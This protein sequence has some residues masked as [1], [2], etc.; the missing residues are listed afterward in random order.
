MET[1]DRKRSFTAI[2][3]HL[4]KGRFSKFDADDPVVRNIVSVQGRMRAKTQKIVE[5]HELRMGNA[6]ETPLANLKASKAH[7]E[8]EL[9]ATLPMVDRQREATGAEVAKLQ[10]V[11]DD[12][13]AD[14]ALNWAYAKETRE[15]VKSLPKGVR[16]DF[17]SNALATGQTRAAA[18]VLGVPAYLSGLSEGERNLF[19]H[20]YKEESHPIEAARIRALTEAQELLDTGGT[21]MISEVH[22]LFNTVELD[23]AEKHAEKVRQAEVG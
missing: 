6:M 11:I 13:L 3:T 14:G 12:S 16:G 18:A 10:K 7:A 8:K 5:V 4:A 17:V 2:P 23:A 1:H 22:S 9:A 19:L 15:H 20:R 21:A